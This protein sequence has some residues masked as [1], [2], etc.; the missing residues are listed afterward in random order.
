MSAGWELGEVAM[1]Y[2]L[3]FI[4]DGI[5]GGDETGK[6]TEFGADCS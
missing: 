5:T 6:G 3:W 2:V 1:R 4:G